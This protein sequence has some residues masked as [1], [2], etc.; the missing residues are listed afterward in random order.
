MTRYHWEKLHD[1][2]FW[3]VKGLSSICF[4]VNSPKI[5]C[6][7]GTAKII[8]WGLIY[9]S[10]SVPSVKNCWLHGFVNPYH[11]NRCC[12]CCNNIAWHCHDL[13]VRW[14]HRFSFIKYISCWSDILVLC[15]LLHCP[16]WLVTDV[17]HPKYP[18]GTMVL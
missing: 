11:M 16:F 14:P 8:F 7:L 18:W 10:F 15:S 9:M 3:G 6:L 5:I 13:V 4:L 2:H 17:N 12:G 1:N